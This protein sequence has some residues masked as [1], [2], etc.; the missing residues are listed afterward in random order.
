MGKSKIIFNGQTLIDLT[1][2][3]VTAET[4][5]EGI[6]AHGADGEV[7]LGVMKAAAGG[8]IT[9]LSGTVTPTSAYEAALNV[10]LPEANFTLLFM[11]PD[12]TMSSTVA[13]S[14]TSSLI[15]ISNNA[16]NDVYWHTWLGAKN[17]T[18]KHS[19]IDIDHENGTVEVVYSLIVAEATDCFIS[20]STYRWYYAYG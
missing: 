9:V 19:R 15:R 6:T 3:T 12:D 1:G 11:A 10:P 20:G 8:G 18:I 2:D 7:I 5:L 14:K 17:N 13:A 16:G 4:L